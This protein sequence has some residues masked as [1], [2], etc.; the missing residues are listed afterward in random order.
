MLV[1]P[2]TDRDLERLYREHG[3]RLWRALVAYTGDPEVA[4]DAMAE[5]FAQGLSRGSALREP[6]R[7]IWRV[8]F[9]VAAGELKDRRRRLGGA[10]EPVA[11]MEEPAG[12]LVAALLQ[13]SPNQRA[14]LV[15]HYY[16]GY[17][18]K[19]IAGII[20]AS[21]ATVRVHLS[22]G[23]KRLRRILEEPDE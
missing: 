9:R 12:E 15:L 8:A 21:A 18:T 19:E 10:R 20:G 7:W 6:L 22:K 14:S 2:G 3:D 4:S 17:P 11:N 23:R 5:A 13:L 1:R 16:A